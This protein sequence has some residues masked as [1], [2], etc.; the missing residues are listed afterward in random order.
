MSTKKTEKSKIEEMASAGVHFGHSFS[1][2]NPNMDPY[3]EGAKGSVHIINLEETEKKLDE[4][5]ERLKELKEQGK[6]VMFVC[7]KPEFKGIVTETAKDCKMPY[8]VNRFLGGMITNFKIIKK[9][10]DYY[11][12]ILEQQKSGELE[13][14]YT[15]QERVKISKEMEGLERKFGGLRK[16]EKIPDAIFVIDVV[17]DKLAVKEA[18]M[19]GVEVIGI[20]DTNAN[21]LNLDLFIPANDDSI[22]SVKYILGEIKKAF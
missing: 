10:I 18:K 13:R 17:K 21:P 8:V 4:A 16:L 20:A 22:T 7:T 2:K 19:A 6:V 12:K 1:K 11:N 5:V 14:K 15:K 3:I 9:R